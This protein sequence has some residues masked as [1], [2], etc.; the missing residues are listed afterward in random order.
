MEVYLLAKLGFKALNCKDCSQHWQ[1]KKVE[2]GGGGKYKDC[3]GSCYRIIG[4]QT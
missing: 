4:K 2:E 3:I 1:N